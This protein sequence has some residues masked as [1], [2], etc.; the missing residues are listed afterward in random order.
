MHR[1][2]LFLTTLIVFSL[3]SGVVADAQRVK[4]PEN[5]ASSTT[6]EF[7]Y[8]VEFPDGQTKAVYQADS[9]WPASQLHIF[10]PAY[11][12]A[13]GPM[14]SSGHTFLTVKDGVVVR[15][16]KGG[17]STGVPAG[18]YVVLGRR[19]VGEHL[20]KFKVGDKVV[21]SHDKPFP[22]LSFTGQL[23]GMNM[24]RDAEKL[25]G[26]DGMWG[27]STRTNIWGMEVTV[28]NGRVVDKVYDGDSLILDGDIVLSGSRQ[29]RWFLDSSVFPGLKFALD[30][31]KVSFSADA[32]SYIY[33]CQWL[34][35]QT[36]SLLK[37]PESKDFNP[38]A[39]VWAGDS[40][41]ILDEVQTLL[42]ADKVAEAWELWKKA[43]D[44]AKKSFYACSP[45][46]G[47]DDVRGLWLFVLPGDNDKGRQLY[48]LLDQK[49]F[50]WVIVPLQMNATEE[51]VQLAM[52]EF[53][54]FCH[55][56][57]IK[58]SLWTWIPTRLFTTDPRN[59]NHKTPM[60]NV[61][62][63]N[64]DQIKVMIDQ[65]VGFVKEFDADG[66]MCDFEGYSPDSGKMLEDFL[67]TLPA[68]DRAA[69]RKAIETKQIGPLKPTFWAW[70]RYRER[71]LRKI[72]AL[73]SAELRKSKPDIK[74]SISPEA[75]D[76]GNLKPVST[77]WPEWLFAG[78]FD[79]ISPQ[80]Y[81]CAPRAV[82]NRV[83]ALSKFIP[84][85]VPQVAS[86]VLYNLAGSS[87]TYAFEPIHVIQSINAARQGGSRGVYF[88]E[89]NWIQ[90]GKT[91]ELIEALKTGPFR[92]S[93]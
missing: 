72:V 1:Q 47:P 76:T 7:E 90:W 63:Y 37:T 87:G 9:H 25:I 67:E 34:L 85:D 23:D 44:L 66:V 68:E 41:K 74:I 56:R 51:K 17:L 19:A 77:L 53:V 20:N 78:Y 55:A 33:Y 89:S 38:Q 80:H 42:K 61:D 22:A 21:V 83:R 8:T 64:D 4:V 88:F 65:L 50:N 79:E 31:K 26:Y 27:S 59:P 86:I 91:V 40:T 29:G 82:E 35:N 73:A 11:F 16:E 30:G 62:V 5:S 18:C 36:Q 69:A 12:R 71:I 54:N 10:T 14:R 58:V 70:A 92:V 48:W 39:G 45:A 75:G 6:R 49:I 3:V 28:R 13:K 43:F 57:G 2:G 52:K 81:H 46:F 60:K 24:F 15:K 93:E 84:A 32:Q